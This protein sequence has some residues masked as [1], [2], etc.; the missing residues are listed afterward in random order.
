MGE[1]MLIKELNNEEDKRQISGNILRSL[2][3][4]LV[5]QN[6]M[7]NILIKVVNYHFLYS[8]IGRK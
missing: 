2:P 7:K 3:N 4:W 8:Y 6:L 5:F 1:K